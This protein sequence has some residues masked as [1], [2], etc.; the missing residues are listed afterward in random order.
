MAFV[1]ALQNMAALRACYTRNILPICEKLINSNHRPIKISLCE[2]YGNVIY[3]LY[4]MIFFH[5]RARLMLP[6]ACHEGP[7]GEKSYS[8]TI[9]LTSAPDGGEWSSPRPGCLTP[10]NDTRYP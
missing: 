6:T 5:L 9:Y 2:E 10:G 3:F 7:E 4:I 8:S 1:S